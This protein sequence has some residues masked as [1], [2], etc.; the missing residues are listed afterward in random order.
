MVSL[1]GKELRNIAILTLFFLLSPK[2][3]GLDT[4]VRP[5]D[6][7]KERK[8]EGRERDKKRKDRGEPCSTRTTDAQTD[9]LTPDT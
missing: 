2:D 6:E 4:R 9:I 3:P 8:R 5:E 7:T 1:Y